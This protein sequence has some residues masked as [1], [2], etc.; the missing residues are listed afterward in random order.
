MTASWLE[1]PDT[2]VREVV[3]RALA[4]D[5]GALGDLTAG[6]VPPG[7]AVNAVLS[8]REYGVLAGRA[9]AAEAFRAVDSEVD[10]RWRAVDGDRLVPGY[11]IARI[12]ESAPVEF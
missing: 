10:V 11:V 12:S 7:S 2:A 5:L 3:A 6:L 4:E 1:P 9:C 8:A